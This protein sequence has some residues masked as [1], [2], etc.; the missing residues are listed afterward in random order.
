MGTLARSGTFIRWSATG[1][2]TCLIAAGA[3]FAHELD[4][5]VPTF[6]E[7]A[8]LSSTTN[9][10]GEGAKWELVTTIP[11]GNPQTD[12]D[13]FTKGGET[14]VSVGTLAT[15]PNAGGQTIVKLTDNGVVAPTYVTGHPSASCLSGSSGVTGLQH[16]VE[17]TPKGGTILNSANAFADKR[18]AQL[19]V[20]ATD[21]P[22]RCHDQ[23]PLGVS[24]TG[25][26]P[27]GG[28]EL[29]DIEDPAKP[30]EI[31]LTTHVGQAHT[32]NVDP[33]RPHIAYV[34]SSDNVAVDSEGKRANDSGGNAFDGIEVVDMSS[35][36]NFAPGTSLDDKR[37]RCNPQVFRYRWP[38]AAV[39]QA[40]SY[41]Q[42]GACHEL[43]IY[44][45]DRITCSAVT[46]TAMFDFKGAF[47]D[48]GTPAD[49][50]DDRLRGTP[51]PC[52]RRPTSTEFPGFQTGAQIVD[53]VNGGS[54][55]SQ[56]LTVQKWL[57]IGAPSL[58]G[59]NWIGTV[60]H[61]GYSANQDHATAPFD[62]TQDI[63]VAHESELTSSGRF[64]LTTDERGGGVIPVGASCTPGPD[65]VKGNGGVH[66]FPV[67]SFSTSPP[68][69]PAAAQELIAKTSDGNRAVFRAGVRT[70]PKA[71]V[72]TSHVFHQIP[73]QNR[74][75]MAWYSQ[76]TQVVDLV[77]NEN[78][79][80]DFKEAGW[81]I[82]ENA[83]QWVS[84]IF[85][86]QENPDGTFTYWGAT[87]DFILGD[88][89]RNAID[90]Y[91]VT[92]PPP[93]A[94]RGGPKVQYPK[95]AVAGV[96]AGSNPRCART[97]AFDRVDIRPR[98]RRLGFTVR[99]RGRERIR[100]DLFQVTTGKRVI[101]RQ[102]ADLIAKGNRFSVRP[103]GLRRGHYV[104]RLRT[105]TPS[106]LS[107]VRQF[108]L[109]LTKKGFR[110][111]PAFQ[112]HLS[113]Q[114]VEEAVLGRPVFGGSRNTPLGISFKLNENARVGVEIRRGG[115]LVK[116][117]AAKT[118]RAN[119]VHRLRFRGRGRRGVY[120]VV[121]KATATGKSHS[122]TLR[123]RR[124]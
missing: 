79:T 63:I 112:E 84:G 97:T 45:D 67:G 100:F 42:A 1:V 8:P 70:E 61:M 25:L 82:P 53:C 111:A 17:A 48:R 75:F 5:P 93:P 12:L 54:D 10:G 114:L 28:L 4:H 15:G 78:G 11:T 3:A 20:D 37:A 81:F 74:V 32:V 89:G 7:A 40:T 80:F 85:K 71:N 102:V 105:S 39:T 124:I 83:N 92:L 68:R 116:R 49:F 47:D 119:R 103:R 38:S 58:E 9:S 69:D 52:F 57:E 16:D 34:S 113:C 72:C 55:G 88:G 118:Y 121:L 23:G 14:Y 19:L 99:R 56:S 76:G 36:M 90:V 59:V 64:V 24:Q 44:P 65:N 33:K 110:R 77:E 27:Q 117:F 21:A 87:G 98:G 120:S 41:Q 123:A 29:I 108:A 22:G 91:K 95:S 26:V 96:E 60:P 35:C 66:A 18:E 101:R 30:K 62:A 109:V 51:L 107:D 106:G 104:A 115:R 73:G 46:A 50:T 43:E 122:T 31:G 2:A 86:V 6:S 13:F 94:P